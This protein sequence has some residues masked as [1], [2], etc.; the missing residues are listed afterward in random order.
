MKRI[1]VILF[2]QS[3]LFSITTSELISNEN[4]ISGDDGI[5]RMYVNIIGNVKNP[6][7]YLV[8]DGINLMTA[9]SISGGYLPGSKLNK[10]IIYSLDGSKKVIN[11]DD[12]LSSKDK[13][14]KFKLLPH[15][16]IYIKEKNISRILTSTNLPS[17]ILGILNVALTLERTN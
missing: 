8:Y 6:G 13:N 16:T 4:Y 12:I 11:L 15:D 1:I 17:I 2:F 10:I 14:S 3:F 9:I 7:T 5:I